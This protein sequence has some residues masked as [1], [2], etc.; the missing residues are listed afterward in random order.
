MDWAISKDLQ[1][2]SHQDK[3]GEPILASSPEPSEEQTQTGL[4]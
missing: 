3:D 2:G 4:F 1:P